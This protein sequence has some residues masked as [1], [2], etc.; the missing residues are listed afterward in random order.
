M[1]LVVQTPKSMRQDG[2][3]GASSGWIGLSKYGS[4]FGRSGKTQPQNEP[5]G[6]SG[7]TPFKVSQA[8]NQDR[9][10]PKRSLQDA[11][12]NMRLVRCFLIRALASCMHGSMHRSSASKL[13]TWLR[14]GAHAA[15]YLPCGANQCAV[16]VLT[17]ICMADEVFAL[18]GVTKMSGGDSTRSYSRLSTTDLAQSPRSQYTPTDLSLIH[19]SEPTRPY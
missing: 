4:F 1:L 11:F 10:G 8:R 17:S 2:A 16:P 5:N 12:A 9:G 6:K 13:Q 18:Q 14:V 19:I 3:S 7:G 15:L